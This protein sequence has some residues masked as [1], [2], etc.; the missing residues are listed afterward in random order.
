MPFLDFL[1]KKDFFKGKDILKGSPL[2]KGQMFAT[3]DDPFKEQVRGGDITGIVK[4]GATHKARLLQLAR[5]PDR[6]V[7]THSII[8]LGNLEDIALKDLFL[9]A[10]KDP[11]TSVRKYSAWAL[12]VL[13]VDEGVHQLVRLLRDTS[14]E[15]RDFSAW[16]LAKIGVPAVSPLVH[17]LCDA[18]EDLSRRA[19]WALTHIG[20]E[21]VA[22]LV[23]LLKDEN[24]EVRTKSAEA[25]GCIGDRRSLSAL[26]EL[27]KDQDN[28]V[29]AVVVESIGTLG[30]R[31]AVG[32]LVLLVDDLDP[33]VRA[34]AAE[35][36]GKMAV[37][38][39][40]DPLI[41]L[42]DDPDADVRQTA[43]KYLEEIHDRRA[44]E[45]L[46]R[47][48]NAADNE[49]RARTAVA[50]GNIGDDRAVEPLMETLF[51]LEPEVR[52]EAA[53]ALG[54]LA[55]ERAIDSLIKKLKDPVG[56]VRINVIE[57]LGKIGH[58]RAVNP[59]I[60]MID[61]DDE[62]VRSQ[63]IMALGLIGDKE[64]VPS[65]VE[66]LKQ[67]NLDL[68][69]KAVVALGKIGDK[70]AVEPLIELLEYSDPDVRIGASDALRSMQ[71]DVTNREAVDRIQDLEQVISACL[72]L[73]KEHSGELGYY[74]EVFLPSRLNKVL[75]IGTFPPF[76]L[77]TISEGY[78]L[79]GD[80]TNA[81]Q[82]MEKC[83][84]E[85][86]SIN[87]NTSVEL[88]QKCAKFLKKDPKR[89][90][91]H[92]EKA[93]ILLTPRAKDYVPTVVN[94]AEKLYLI[95]S[96]KAESIEMVRQL[97]YRHADACKEAGLFEK[98]R[99]LYKTVLDI[100]EYRDVPMSRAEAMENIA[101][102]NDELG[103]DPVKELIKAGK[104]LDLDQNLAFLV[105][106]IEYFEK[107]HK[108]DHAYKLRLECTDLV[109]K[110]D[111]SQAIAHLEAAAGYVHKT[112]TEDYVDLISKAARKLLKGGYQKQAA[113]LLE[114]HMFLLTRAKAH[115]F[116]ARLYSLM[117]EIG[118][119]GEDVPAEVAEEAPE[120]V[121]IPG[122]EGSDASLAPEEYATA[123]GEEDV[124]EVIGPEEVGTSPVAEIPPDLEGVDITVG[125]ADD[126][127][128]GQPDL[129]PDA[130]ALPP[131]GAPPPGA[132]PPP[133]PE[134][135]DEGEVLGGADDFSEGA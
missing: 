52:K 95:E 104:A 98:A 20:T 67:S 73:R 26:V 87:V 126:V 113:E 27:L 53:V 37:P 68:R 130:S 57:A 36:L 25:L 96:D 2:A 80:E 135:E 28:E 112:N 38:E 129:P 70:A 54:K 48:L 108:L 22:P 15:V 90:S 81:I 61:D 117:N 1:K 42:L 17:A 7:R 72:R 125:R 24:V 18:D 56:D 34:K 106:N 60:K 50:L 122:D 14:P 21:A 58:S 66:L 124:A 13:K 120:E 103:E 94:A 55:D 85:Y 102:V 116:A 41:E 82:Y 44:I 47:T 31:R 92:L 10:L 16:A 76:L 43:V 30:D 133:Q 110:T 35:A 6:D 91:A 115:T 99:E 93:A 127:E 83:A 132:I 49:V 109:E 101:R 119:I 62:G 59:L 65:L 100:P 79:L 69:H 71:I 11:S 78:N 88:H 111:I 134:G 46:I 5:D 29:R 123:V 12:G 8:A 114:K 128:G 97:L 32:A 74:R 19:K 121:A 77:E 39:V 118:A 105:R 9:G 64:A 131:S 107:A 33:I 4:E 86:E 84:A 3:K 23:E 63:T 51:D 45:P 75:E 40:V 89:A